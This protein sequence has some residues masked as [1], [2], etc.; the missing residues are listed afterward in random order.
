MHQC[1]AD[2]T[3]ANPQVDGIATSKIG[4]KKSLSV[5]CGEYRFRYLSPQCPNHPHILMH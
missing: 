4:M 1:Q 5:H 3:T 2:S